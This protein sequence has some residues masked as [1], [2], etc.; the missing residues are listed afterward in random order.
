LESIFSSP[1]SRRY[2]RKQIGLWYAR[3]R[4]LFDG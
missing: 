2:S 3:E 4:F 1:V